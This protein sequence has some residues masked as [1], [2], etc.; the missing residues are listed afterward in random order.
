MSIISF[1]LYLDFVTFRVNGYANDL[2]C[3]NVCLSFV[4]FLKW[5]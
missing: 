3:F 5:P 2:L 1:E 4:K